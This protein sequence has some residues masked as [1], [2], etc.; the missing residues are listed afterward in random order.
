MAPVGSMLSTGCPSA[1]SFW[2]PRCN[3]VS[4][5]VSAGFRTAWNFAMASSS[6]SIAAEAVC[7][8]LGAQPPMCISMVFI[9]PITSVGPNAQPTRSPVAAKPFEMPSMKI[10]Y[11]AISGTSAQ[12]VTWSTPNDSI[13]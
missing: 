1:L 9:F 7:S 6:S 4:L 3:A 10:V 11:F 12:G 13:Q 2:K 5:R 8:G